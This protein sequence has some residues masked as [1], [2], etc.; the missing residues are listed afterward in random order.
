M[1][2]ISLFFVLVPI[3]FVPNERLFSLFGILLVLSGVPVY[4]LFIWGKCR[5]NIFN[6]VSSKSY[7]YIAMTVIL[8]YRETNIHIKYTIRFIISTY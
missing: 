1:I 7:I 6:T 2:L 4:L 8:L 3:I 5:P